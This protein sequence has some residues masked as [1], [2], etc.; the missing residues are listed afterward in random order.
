MSVPDGK[1][2]A[3]VDN[4]TWEAVQDTLAR[5]R[6]DKQA[7]ASVKNPS[8]LAGLVYDDKGNRM[9]P[10]YTRRKNQHYGYYISQAMLQYREDEAGSVIRI[11][12]K[13]LDDTIGQL[14]LD[15]LSNPPRLLGILAPFQ[16]P[17]VVLESAMETAKQ[18]AADW[19]ELPIKARIPL[20]S[21]LV[22]RIVVAKTEITLT[23][24]RDNLISHLTGKTSST[25]VSDGRHVSSPL[26]LTAQVNLQ[27]SGIETKLVYPSGPAPKVHQRS[28]KALQQALLKSLQWNEDLLCGAVKSI[29][30]LID[31]DGLNPRQTHRLRRLAFLAPDIIE[32]VVSGDVPDTLTLEKLKQEFPLDWHAQR[33]HFGLAKP[34]H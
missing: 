7:K 30:A 2:A 16:L 18:L 21:A 27:R 13:I 22:A 31:R 6:K 3:I 25:P 15:L 8:L 19:V 29:D 11:P 9:S 32:R 10:T 12:S 20:I 1:H 34:A 23:L 28:V 4:I 5:N 14:L 24:H 17:G 26:I 33:Q